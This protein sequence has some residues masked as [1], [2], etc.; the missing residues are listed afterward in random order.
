V[1]AL[2]PMRFTYKEIKNLLSKS[3]DTPVFVSNGVGGYIEVRPHK[4][5]SDL[6]NRIQKLPITKT[7]FKD[8]TVKIYTDKGEAKINYSKYPAS[9]KKMLLAYL[10]NFEDLT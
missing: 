10:E 2:L 3:E 9:I 4:A 7:E 5:Y 8:D 6:L 1:A